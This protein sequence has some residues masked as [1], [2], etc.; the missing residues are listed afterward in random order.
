MTNTNTVRYTRT[1]QT[2]ATCII[3]S[4]TVGDYRVMLERMDGTVFPLR[5]IGFWGQK[6]DHVRRT[7]EMF[8]FQ[9]I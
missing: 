1:S 2:P 5:M 3:K 8:K 4:I 7:V 9:Q 6:L